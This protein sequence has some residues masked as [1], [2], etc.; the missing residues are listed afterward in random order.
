MLRALLR[1]GLTNVKNKT[2]K[3]NFFKKKVATI[4]VAT[5]FVMLN[6]E[7]KFIILI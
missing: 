4:A 7:D 2:T 6:E 3:T 1:F 5:I